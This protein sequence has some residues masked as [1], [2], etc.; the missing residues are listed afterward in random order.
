MSTV[1]RRL[2]PPAVVLVATAWAVHSD[3]AASVP[4]PRLR[5]AL[6]ALLV[7]VFLFAWRLRSARAARAAVILGLLAAW[8]GHRSD[9]EAWM[10]T[11]LLVPVV[12][13]FDFALVAWLREA[14]LG[15]RRSMLLFVA[16]ACEVAVLA[17]P[18]LERL[19]VGVEDV[20]AWWPM[21]ALV[22]GATLVILRLAL[23]PTPLAAGWLGALLAA[24]SHLQAVQAPGSGPPGDLA[25]GVGPAPQTPVVWLLAAALVLL[26]ALVERAFGFAFEDTLTGLPG[27]RALDQRLREIG[28]RYVIAMVDIDHFKRV[29]DRHGHDVGDQALR[30]VAR[31]LRR[32]PRGGAAFRYGGEEFALIFAGKSIQAVGPHLEALRASIAGEPFT[33]RAAGRPRKKPGTGRSKQ[34][35]TQKRSARQGRTLKLTVSIGAAAR[36]SKARTPEQVLQAADRALYRAKRAGRNRIVSA[37]S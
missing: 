15:S 20:K 13:P 3:L 7:A 35:S 27:R 5:L 34:R 19:P 10:L 36:G 8:L 24:T 32:V 21:A 18:V 26:L 25:L 2:L 17:P 4:A 1:F 37:K 23:R 30:W 29:N 6:H 22:A 31:R 14:S 9:A 16:L 12:L 11:S 33:L 28:G